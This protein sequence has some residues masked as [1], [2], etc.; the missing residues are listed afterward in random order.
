MLSENTKLI[1]LIPTKY[2]SV[3]QVQLN[4]EFETRYIG[5]LDT[6]GEGTLLTNRK[7]KHIFHKYGGEQGS[8][9][10]NHSLLTDGTIFFKW[11]VIDFSGRKLVT[12][13]PYMLTHGKCF[14]FGSQGWDLQC[15][16][17]LEEFGLNKAREF[18]ARQVIQENLFS[19]AV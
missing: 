4:L 19:E 16:L 2:P 18:E 17:P 9:G 7:P 12:S 5:K 10:I 1:E 11:L 15:F 6:A 13:R 14:K 8:V 3:F